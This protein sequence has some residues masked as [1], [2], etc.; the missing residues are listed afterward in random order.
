MATAVFNGFWEKSITNVL[1]LVSDK[2]RTT[3]YTFYAYSVGFCGSPQPFAHNYFWHSAASG[4][5]TD[6]EPATTG[7]QFDRPL[8]PKK[9]RNFY[10]CPIKV[11]TFE[12]PPFIMLSQLFKDNHN[13]RTNHS[14]T[15]F[16]GIEGTIVRVLSQRLNFMPILVSPE[17]NERWG[18]CDK[19]ETNCNGSLKLVSERVLD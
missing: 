12:F 18:A 5:S 4:N 19:A 6:K 10:N 14:N 13:K 7:F 9:C 3:F 17:D 1:F 11:A 15:F 16:D 2:Q 8:F